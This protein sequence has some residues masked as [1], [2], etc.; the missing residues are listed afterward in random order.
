VQKEWKKAK[1]KKFYTQDVSSFESEVIKSY[2]EDKD[3]ENPK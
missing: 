1:R 2:D 3:D